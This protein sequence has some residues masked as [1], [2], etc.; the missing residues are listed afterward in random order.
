MCLLVI[1]GVSGNLSWFPEWPDWLRN[2]AQATTAVVF[3]VVRRRG[4]A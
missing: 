1:A 3:V 4:A 2:I